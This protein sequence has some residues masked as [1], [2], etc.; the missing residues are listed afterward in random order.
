M[1]IVAIIQ[2]RLESIRLPNKVMKL[3]GEYPMIELL[4]KRLN[5]SK[6]IS[7]IVVATSKNS[8]NEHLINHV[9]KLGYACEVGSED[10]VL[11]RFFQVAK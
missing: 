2:A 8:I 1:N 7:K 11:D 5:K 6:E 3:M 4:I 10:D 9:R